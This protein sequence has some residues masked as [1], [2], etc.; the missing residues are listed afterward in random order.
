MKRV[1]GVIVAM[2]GLGLS[3]WAQGVRVIMPAEIE[4]S[5]VKGEPFTAAARTTLIQ[6]LPDGTKKTRTVEDKIAR[7][8]KGRIYREQHLPWTED[9][10]NPIYY[11]NIYDPVV[12]RKIHIDPQNHNVIIGPIDRPIHYDALEY[13]TLRATRPGEQIKNEKLG[14]KEFEGINA[15]GRRTLHTFPAGIFGNPVS[16]VSVDECWYEERMGVD[17]LRRRSDP[18]SGEQVTELINLTRAEP[19]PTIF[20]PP[21]GY[22]R[23]APPAR[24]SE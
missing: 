23:Q 13:L 12:R 4:V 18:R 16:F 11:V 9:V 15:W 3:L 14:T 24:H 6:V 21:P 19:D 5:E 17:V 8:S 7:D 20:Q 2:L 22:T 1:P 10:N